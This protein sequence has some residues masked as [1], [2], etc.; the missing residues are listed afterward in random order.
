MNVD[1]A[2]DGRQNAAEVRQHGV[3]RV[4]NDPSARL[5]DRPG[6][7]IERAGQLPVRAQFVCV[8]EPAVPGNVGV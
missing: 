6:Y 7:E 5:A 1:G 8:G 3:T 4:V 2:V